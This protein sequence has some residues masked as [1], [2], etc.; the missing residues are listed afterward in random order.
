MSSKD[1]APWSS[2]QALVRRGTSFARSKDPALRYRH[3]KLR[4]RESTEVTRLWR[5]RGK[6]NPFTGGTCTEV[7]Y[8]ERSTARHASRCSSIESI[9]VHQNWKGIAVPVPARISRAPDRSARTSHSLQKSS[10]DVWPQISSRPTPKKRGTAG[11]NGGLARHERRFVKH[12]RTCLAKQR[13]EPFVAGDSNGA[14]R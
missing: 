14:E 2:V 1:H 13:R 5:C 7:P 3:S 10:G 8:D 4:R 6:A 9:R 12:R 11:V